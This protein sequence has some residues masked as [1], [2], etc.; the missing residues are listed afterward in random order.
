MTG[1]NIAHQLLVLNE[2]LIATIP[3]TR[4]FCGDVPLNTPLPFISIS[5]VSGLQR[6]EVSNDAP[7]HLVTDRVQITVY[8]STYALQKS[9][10]G[11]VRSALKYLITDKNGVISR[12][13]VASW[14]DWYYSTIDGIKCVSIL[15]DVEGP[16]VRDT[17]VNTYEQSADFIIRYI[18]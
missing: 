5:H 3:K 7:K 12:P 14:Y 17:G 16:D 11:L 6:N 10:I 13:A 18:R 1:V 2:T 15:P 4:V 9:Y 8:A